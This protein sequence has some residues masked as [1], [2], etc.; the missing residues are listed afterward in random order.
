MLKE[1]DFFK[2]I[3]S[4]P[5]LLPDSQFCPLTMKIA[6]NSFRC[7]RLANFLLRPSFISIQTTL[8]LATVLQ[9]GLLPEP[10]WALLNTTKALA[11]SLGLDTSRLPGVNGYS[12]IH[13]G[14]ELWYELLSILR[15]MA[16]VFTGLLV[17]GRRLISRPASG[18]SLLG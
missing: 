10:A 7:L 9:N 17:L 12:D 16:D 2:N 8:L 4:I 5:F 11:K 3:V 14:L 6:R 13:L 18:D 15:A 1:A